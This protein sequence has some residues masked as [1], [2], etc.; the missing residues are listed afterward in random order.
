MRVIIATKPIR[1]LWGYART[2]ETIGM[3][4]IS[5]TQRWLWQLADP[6]YGLRVQHAVP[7]GYPKLI[8]PW[9]ID[10]ESRSPSPWHL[11]G[12]AD[13]RFVEWLFWV[14]TISK[15]FL[16]Y[17]RCLKKNMVYS[18]VIS[19]TDLL[20]VPI[21]YI[22]PKIQGISQQNMAQ[23]MVLTY[24]HFWILNSHWSIE[25]TRADLTRASPLDHRCPVASPS[26]LAGT[27][28]DGILRGH[29]EGNYGY[30]MVLYDNHSYDMLW[31][32]GLAMVK[33]WP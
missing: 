24:L 12:S 26:P 23:K 17:W 7:M 6:F 5:T 29:L 10:V 14:W 18:M 32:T 31:L 9:D 15:K 25:D 16:F 3:V 2:I 27:G 1:W 22:R 30:Q 13:V 33:P 8:I 19:G 20:E 21:P 11:L 4:E 28:K